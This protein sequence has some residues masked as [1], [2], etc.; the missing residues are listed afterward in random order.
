MELYN[1]NW[2]LSISFNKYLWDPSMLWCV[3]IYSFLLPVVIHCT[4][5]LHFVPVW[6]H[7]ESNYY[8]HPYISRNLH[9]FS[10]VYTQKRNCWITVLNSTVTNTVTIFI[11]YTNFPKWLQPIYTPTEISFS[12]TFL[13]KI[14]LSIYCASH[15]A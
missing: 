11:K 1:M 2:V 5:T 3:A 7:N 10:W 6:G 8:D 15:T 12:W 14:M 9:S 4:N 13:N